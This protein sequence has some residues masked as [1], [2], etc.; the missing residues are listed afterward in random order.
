MIKE[1]IEQVRNH[2]QYPKRQDRD[3]NDQGVNKYINQ[4]V[5]HREDKYRRNI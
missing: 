3:K 5:Y 2:I 1:K 4:Q